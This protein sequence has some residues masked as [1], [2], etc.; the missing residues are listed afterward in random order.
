MGNN[1]DQ[2][3]EEFYAKL[4]SNECYH[5]FVT[6]R[7][8]LR[9]LKILPEK[10]QK[11]F[12]VKIANMIYLKGY[13]A[14]EKRELDSLSLMF[15][16]EEIVYRQYPD[17]KEIALS[18]ILLNSGV[19]NVML[20]SGEYD[21]LYTFQK[22]AEEIF[23]K[24]PTNE[25]IGRECMNCNAVLQAN[26]LMAASETG[27]PAPFLSSAEKTVDNMETISSDFPLNEYMNLLYCNT[28][29]TTANE[30]LYHQNAEKF[31]KCIGLLKNLVQTR[32]FDVPKD[33]PG[34]L[35]MV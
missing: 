10:S 19:L 24:F 4:Q 1:V 26:Y 15:D 33:I 31:K 5:V 14:Y 27:T 2:L 7:D 18:F 22:N 21:N 9:S 16:C 20:K 23:N 12:S 25:D 34:Y 30:F 29:E 32:T 8:L 17:D 13:E 3:V 28:L 6:L 11:D 35:K